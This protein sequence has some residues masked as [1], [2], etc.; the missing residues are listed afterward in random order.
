MNDPILTEMQEI[1]RKHAERYKFDV[2]AMCKD[3]INTQHQREKSGW[4]LLYQP[5]SSES[6]SL[7]TNMSLEKQLAE[8]K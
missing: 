7:N 5:L 8:N 6:C 2:L 1:K 3:I 4:K